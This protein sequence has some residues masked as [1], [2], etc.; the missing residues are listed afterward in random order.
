MARKNSLY[1]GFQKQVRNVLLQDYADNLT[2]TSR[3]INDKN[4]PLARQFFPNM[5][6]QHLD[7]GHWGEFDYFQMAIAVLFLIPV[8]VHS[9]RYVA[10]LIVYLG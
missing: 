7:A 9:E 1:K 5:Q 2:V 3:Y 4:I 6:L 8:L 10:S